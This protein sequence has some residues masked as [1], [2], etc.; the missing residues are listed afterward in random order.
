[1]PSAD[2][3]QIDVTVETTPGSS[4]AYT[5]GI[6][7]QVNEKLDDYE[8]IIET[9]FLSVGGGDFGGMGGGDASSASYTIQLVPAA[10]RD[11]TTT[12]VVQT[13]DEDLATIPSVEITVGSLDSGMSFG[14][15]K[16]GRASCRERVWSW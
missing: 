16:I 5:E 6:V 3:G 2:E 15:P 8:A 13:L 9:S 1:M 7:E 4:L 10:D 14:D 11:Q 12:E